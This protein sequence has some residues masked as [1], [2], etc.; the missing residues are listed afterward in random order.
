MVGKARQQL[1]MYSRR[2]RSTRNAA[3]TT[4]ASASAN[5]RTTRGRTNKAKHPRRGGGNPDTA[6]VR[7]SIE[8][9][10]VVPWVKVMRPPA[11]H[12]R[13]TFLVEKW[14][15]PSDLTAAE[16]EVY[17]AKQK[18][19]EE[20]RQRQ[21][22]WQQQKREQEQKEKAEEEQRVKEEKERAM[23]TAA[24]E[25]AAAAEHNG[26]N[27]KT[28]EESKRDQENATAKVVS[29]T[30]TNDLTEPKSDI[31]QPVAETAA[32][33]LALE[34]TTQESSGDGG[35][36]DVSVSAPA[37]TPLMHSA[38]GLSEQTQN[39]P[40]S[41]IAPETDPIKTDTNLPETKQELSQNNGSESKEGPQANSSTPANLSVS[42]T[43]KEEP[44]Q[45]QQQLSV[46]NASEVSE[47][48]EPSAK[49]LRV[50]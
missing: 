13:R 9:P 7:A 17:D 36:Q 49:K 1:A 33:A 10:P 23:A 44:Q 21:L 19:K 16:R 3:A 41:S 27:A 2:Q 34:Q 47:P 42:Q 50:E 18:E 11:L 31:D 6:R 43:S 24:A 26:E 8:R 48:S 15:R 32:S 22:K 35:A 20:E 30:P 4:N 46:S 12:L 14:V 28:A 38:Q 45:D 37:P 39:Q 29:D 25:A 40:A 5:A